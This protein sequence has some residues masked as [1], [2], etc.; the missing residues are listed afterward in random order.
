MLTWFRDKAKI[1]LIAIIVTFV[2]LIFVQWGTGQLNTRRD[3]TGAVARIE[4]REIAPAEY[5]DYFTLAYQR[6]ESAMMSA[7]D[8]SPSQELTAMAGVIEEEAWED[9]INS[10]LERLYLDDL[11]WPE[12]GAREALA[13]MLVQLELMGVEDSKAYLSEMQRMPGFPAQLQQVVRQLRFAAFPAATRLQN[14]AS[15]EEVEYLISERYMPISARYI[16][17]SS[18]PPIPG[19]DD[20]RAFYDSHQELFTTPPFGILRFAAVSVLPDSS[21][22]LRAMSAVDSLAFNRASPP[23]TVVLTRENFLLFTMSDTLPAAG[24]TTRPFVA[25]SLRGGYLQA[26][27][28]VSVLSIDPSS[29][30]RSSL[31]TI[32]IAHWETAVLPGLEALRWTQYAVEDNLTGLL[33]G[34]IPWSD[35]LTIADWGTIRIEE[36]SPLNSSLP[37]AMVAF[38]LDT[39][40]TD[41]IGPVFFSP[42]FQGGYPALIAAKKL[43][44]S[45]ESVTMSY[46]EAATTGTLLITAYSA[47][48]AE[49]SLAVAGREMQRM[50]D[51]GL[52]LGAYAEV[53]SLPLQSTPEFTVSS[54]RQAAASD[55]DA[56]GGILCSLDFA[57]DALVAPLMTP[58]GPYRTGASAVV[59]E[60]TVRNQLPMPGDPA[61]L[62]P[63]YLS[64]QAAHS[65]GLIGDFLALLRRRSEVEDLR[66]EYMAAMDSLRS[67]RPPDLPAGY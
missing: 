40:W 32:S 48:Q 66:E 31:D 52:T 35:S 62:S 34:E 56:Y 36:G 24:E 43:D 25:P 19:E 67:Q 58:M 65:F 21:D 55:P 5:D 33:A 9:M 57:L 15:R 7:G 41:S 2:L 17:F 26:C 6:H 59:A 38:A 29:D 11:G 39:V 8:P 4:G 37:P 13:L 54:V 50:V 20:L 18:T 28:V 3:Y 49:S 64:T 45:T 60:V 51:L 53:E 23:D 22:I 12:A 47:I 44:G 42:S 16:I 1:F 63:V 10:E 30:G 14:M 61:V 27:H 46:E